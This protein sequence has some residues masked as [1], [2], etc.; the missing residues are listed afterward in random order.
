MDLA[1][2]IKGSMLESFYPKGWNLREIDR[3]VKDDPAKFAR[4]ERW[5]H[6]KFE[7]IM[8]ESISDFDVMMGHEIAMTIRRARE[9]KR[10][11]VLILPVGPMGMYR[12]TVYFLKDWGVSAS[13][14]HGFN[15]DEWSDG[16]GNTPPPD[17]PGG[18]QGAMDA[19]LYGPLGTLTVPRKQRH[20]ALKKELPTYGQ[21]IAALKKKGAASAVGF[22]IGRA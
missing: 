19:A 7:L 17:A 3:C 1:S 14:V 13:H 16:E 2:T 22:G 20:F 5:W 15:M 8:C 10:S 4:R 9:A 21:Q 6:R 18:F 12:W 11:L